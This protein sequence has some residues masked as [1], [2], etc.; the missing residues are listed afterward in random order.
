[1]SNYV[2]LSRS[3]NANQLVI[4]DGWKPEDI[5]FPTKKLLDLNHIKK[6]MTNLEITENRTIETYE[7]IL[8]QIDMLK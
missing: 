7:E 5:R 2:I 4:M 6:F 3:K 8:K 1:M